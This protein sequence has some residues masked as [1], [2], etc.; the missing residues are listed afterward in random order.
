VTYLVRDE[1]F[2]VQVLERTRKGQS[3]PQIA[4]DLGCCARTVHRARVRLNIGKPSATPVT[5]EQIEKM[6][7]LLDDG[8]SR[9]ETARTLGVSP[10]T[11][12]RHFPGR[13]WTREQANEMSSAI[14]KARWR[15]WTK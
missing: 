3:A 15:A 1:E 12:N 8:A 7:Q 14:Q 5:A 6:R 10:K 2:L 11:V 4:D 13:K 9:C